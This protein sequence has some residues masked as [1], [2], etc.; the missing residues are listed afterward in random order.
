MKAKPLCELRYSSQTTDFFLKKK[1]LGY[2]P[3]P[4]S[5]ELQGELRRWMSHS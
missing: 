4:V 1:G 3:S 5:A 2:F